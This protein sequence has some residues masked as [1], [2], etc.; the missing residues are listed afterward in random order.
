MYGEQCIQSAFMREDAKRF[1]IL[2]RARHCAALTRPWI[3]PEI[4]QT[5]LD[6]MPETFTSVP[7]RGI[8]N[9]EGRL[10]MALYP[11]GT[12]FFR[13]LPASHIRFSQNVDTKQVQAFSQALSI[14]ELL[15]MARLESADMGGGSNRRRTGFR[16]RKRQAITQILI[17]GDVL[18][19]FTDDY[20]LRV[21]RRDQYVTCRDSSQDVQFHI[22]C[23]KIDPATLS[24]EIMEI[25]DIRDEDLDR[26][27]DERGVDLYTRCAW[28]PYTRLWLVEQEINKKI[29]RTSEEPVSPY[30][31]TPFELAPGE[32][33]GRGFIEAN[34]GDVRTLNEL[35]ERLLDF[36]GMCSKFVPCIDYNSQVRASDLAK[37]SGEVIEAR[38]QGGAV[39]DIAF[40]S[41]NKGSDF[42][43]VYQT[44]LE[45]RRDLAVAMLM[46]ADAAPKGERVT[47][48]QIQRIASELEGALGGVYAPIADAQQVPLVERL[49]YQMQRDAILPALP[50]NS[51]DIEAVTGIAALSREADKAKLL[52]LVSTMAQFGPEMT[53]RIDL[54]VLFD[55]LLRQSGIFEP[56]LVKTSE[57]VAA[58]A[59]AAMQQAIEM[60]AQKRLIQVGGDV[61]TNELSPQENTNAGNANAA[62]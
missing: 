17:T 39:Q 37:P 10:L 1:N 57:Q 41:V 18:E 38:V 21:F 54:G 5:E 43:V 4:G 6:K 28:Q 34:L 12:P 56:G 27:Y 40:L 2:E 9:L 3:L 15:M 26:N 11:P 25:A 48:F 13:L 59:S 49:L 45:K 60:E 46:E 8:A 51:M 19:Q 50:R 35:H 32:D 55:T 47:A 61:M 7:S 53:K 23:E 14:Q 52:Q 22:V 16:S 44:A 62:A 36:A 29:I 58:E 42:Q 31:S 20:R 24:P 33:Y 30:M